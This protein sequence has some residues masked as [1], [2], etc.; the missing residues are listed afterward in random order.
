[1]NS[2]SDF[3]SDDCLLTLFFNS[4]DWWIDIKKP[5]ELL[6]R[7]EEKLKKINKQI[8]E[9][10]VIEKGA[11]IRG[12]ISIGEG[13]I[14]SSGAYLSGP[15]II[16]KN[17]TIGPNSVIRPSS[18]LGDGTI[19]YPGAEIKNSIINNKSIVGHFSYVGD[20]II[21]RNCILGGGVITAVN[22]FDLNTIRCK[23]E[24]KIVDTGRLKLGALMG[25]WCKI[26]VGVLIMPGRRIGPN[27]NVGPGIIVYDD[28][29]ENTLV[30][31]KQ[32]LIQKR[33]QIRNMN[34]KNEEKRDKLY[35]SLSKSLVTREKKVI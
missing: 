21:G 5:W 3:V 16:G 4:K 11:T 10:A 32:R 6:N 9:K 7:S 23:V 1:M 2:I 26:G 14:I 12:D 33:I 28:V 34:N 8:S 22:R 31:C 30:L 13:S 35:Q 19:V 15:S 25:D 27:S 17:C 24:E 29:T 20:S 18:I